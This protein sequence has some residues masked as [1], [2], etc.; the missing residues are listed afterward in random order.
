MSDGHI[1]LG[2]QEFKARVDEMAALAATER[3][4]RLAGY[5]SPLRRLLGRLRPH[6]HQPG[7]DSPRS[8]GTLD[9]PDH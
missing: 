4:A 3:A 9:D 1:P 5:K 6:H 7:V 8:N 2:N